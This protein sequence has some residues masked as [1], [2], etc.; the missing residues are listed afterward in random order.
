MERPT[1]APPT[2]IVVCLEPYDDEGPSWVV[3][4]AEAEIVVR[5]GG[6]NA[7]E[8]G[9][10]AAMFDPPAGAFLVARAG[11]AGPPVGGVG[12]RTVLP[13]TGEIRRLWVDPAWRDRGVGRTLMGEVEAAARRLGLSALRLGTGDRQPEAVALYE[14]TG[15]EQVFVDRHGRPVPPRHIRF[16]KDIT[17]SQGDGGHEGGTDGS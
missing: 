3:A 2:D 10:V 1:S 7:G 11:E 15:W 4:Q 9:L 5:Y 12:V 6:L 14:A 8:L 13:D 17:V 16:R